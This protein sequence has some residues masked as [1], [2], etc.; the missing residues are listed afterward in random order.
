MRC[1]IARTLSF[2]IRSI[3]RQTHKGPSWQA[4]ILE[5]RYGPRF[6][7]SRSCSTHLIFLRR[8]PFIAVQNMQRMLA[9]KNEALKKLRAHVAKIDP[10]FAAAAEHGDGDAEV[11]AA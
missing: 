3:S 8:P 1:V 2:L 6:I 5:T 11:E 4:T 10:A 7:K 9:K